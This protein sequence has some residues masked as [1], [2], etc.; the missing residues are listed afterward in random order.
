MIP[1]STSTRA[2]RLPRFA[3]SMATPSP[4]V[5]CAG[6]PTIAPPGPGRKGAGTGSICFAILRGERPGSPQ[7][8]LT[9][10]SG[11]QGARASSGS[12]LAPV[13]EAKLAGR[14]IVGRDMVTLVLLNGAAALAAILVALAAPGPGGAAQLFF[15]AICAYFIVVHSAVLLAGLAGHLTVGGVA[16]LL[17]SGRGP[18]RL[19]GAPRARAIAGPAAGAGALRCGVGLFAARRRGRGRR[20]GVAP[21]VRGHAAVDLGRLHVPHDLSGALAAGACDRRAVAVARLHD[22]GLVSACRKRRRRLVHA[23]VRR[24]A[25]RGARLGQSYGSALRR[26]GRRGRGRAPGPPRLPPG[27]V[28][29]RRVA[30]PDVGAHR[31]HGLELL[32]RGSRPG[33]RALR[34]LR[35]RHPPRRRAPPRRDG[36]G[37]VRGPAHRHRARHQDQRGGARPDHPRDLGA[38]GG[39]A[40]SRGA[41][42]RGEP[43]G[44]H[45]RRLLGRDGRVLVSAEPRGDGQSRLSRRLL[46]LARRALPRDQ[47]GGVRAALRHPPGRRRRGRGIRELA[48]LSR[49][50]GGRRPRRPRGLARVEAGR[51]HALAGLFRLGRARHRLRDADP[52][53]LD[54]LL[55]GQCD[56]LPLGLRPLGQH[57]VRGAGRAPRLGC[58][59]LPDRCGGRR[60]ARAG[61]GRRARRR[62]RP[63]ERAG[64]ASPLAGAPHRHGG[65]C[66]GRR[67]RRRVASTHRSRWRVGASA[68]SRSPRAPPR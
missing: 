36:R 25:R 6:V 24:S 54:T 47:P 41:A 48:A 2:P 31:H 9:Y 67:G 30:V 8:T 53:A 27:I 12:Q 40:G 7:R 35:V 59:R 32:G 34:R 60:R 56:D 18:W 3:S 52:V 43:H 63:R 61:H 64:R 15:A 45:L 44:P 23:P 10:A 42:P 17:A 1:R 37:V 38:P 20:V 11:C 68:P 58:A 19:A 29:A 66:G 46:D 16:V 5:A 13:P 39:G 33:G 57:A 14:S 28:G 49:G 4:A 51:P 62:G 55:G 22:A 21:S 65:G 50:D 26:H